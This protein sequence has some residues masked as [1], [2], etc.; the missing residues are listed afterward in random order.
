MHINVTVVFAASPTQLWQQSAFLE[1]GASIADALKAVAFQQHWPEYDHGNLKTGVY[2]RL[3]PLK[4][5]L[6]DGDRVEVYRPL[7]FDPNESRLR[8][9][10]RRK[11]LAQP[12]TANKRRRKP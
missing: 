7:V 10:A 12:E 4:H 8:R 5:R 3:C 6:N 1:K 11:R 2:G 9:A